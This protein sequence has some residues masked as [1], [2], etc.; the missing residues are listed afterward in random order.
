MEFRSSCSLNV[1]VAAGI[2][3]VSVLAGVTQDCDA[4][5]F[6]LV[7]PRGFWLCMDIRFGQLRSKYAPL[8]ASSSSEYV[9][10][11][12]SLRTSCLPSS[13]SHEGTVLQFGHLHLPIV[14]LRLVSIYVGLLT[15]NLIC[16]VANGAEPKFCWMHR[17]SK[18]DKSVDR[19]LH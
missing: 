3:L 17:G 1:L 4:I 12:A 6:P 2:L 16:P 13:I 5:S 7:Q 9:H 10:C 8:T 18:S 19:M 14:Q 15:S 11:H